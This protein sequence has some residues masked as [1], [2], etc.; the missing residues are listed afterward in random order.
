MKR[1]LKKALMG[2]VVTLA[3]A[4]TTAQAA[5]VR[6]GLDPEPYP[7][8]SQK[9]SAGNWSGFEVDLLDAYCKAANLSCERVEIAWDGLIP[10]LNANKIDMI[11]NSMS[12]TDE[13]KKSI[14]F[15]NAY[16]D[17]PAAFVAPKAMPL[18]INEDGL[19]G[20]IIGVQGSTTHANYA[21]QKLSKVADVKMYGRQDEAN[22]ELL[23]GRVDVLL[24]DSLA[25][26]AF[27]ESD[28]GKDMEIKGTASDPLFGYGVGMGLR[29]GD[30]EL[31]DKMNA[32]I[33]AVNDSGEYTTIM[34]KY[35]KD[36]D[37]SV[38]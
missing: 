7:P 31:K 4:A 6:V 37:V 36:I 33:K 28:E 13:R 35:F 10:A 23:S 3:A 5:D 16:Y 22:S 2:C 1:L 34:K 9:D 38:K 17:T 20:K 25:L 18:E 11:F 24:A 21:Q 32:A 14:D 26:T 27:L 12:I 15:S 30:T 8:F 29:K 19:K